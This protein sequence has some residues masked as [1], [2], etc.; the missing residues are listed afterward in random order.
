MLLSFLENV[1]HHVA[2]VLHGCS[3]LSHRLGLLLILII[4][5]GCVLGSIIMFGWKRSILL[6]SL[7][8]RAFN[9]IRDITNDNNDD[10]DDD[11]DNME[12][13]QL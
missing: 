3:V 11:G 13:A 5:E 6:H 7:L 4:Q 8:K 10:D 2:E 9:D 1:R 12:E